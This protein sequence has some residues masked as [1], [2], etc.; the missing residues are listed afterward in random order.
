MNK[1]V[2][3]D[4]LSNIKDLLQT[5]KLPQWIMT[6]PEIHQ[7]EIEKIFSKK[8]YFIAHESEIPNKGDYVSRWIV[9]DPVLLIRNGEGDINAFI[10]SCTHRGVHLC[11]ADLG[12]KKTFTC[13]YHGWTYNIEGELVGILAGNK[14]YGE[15]MDKKEWGLRKVPKVESYHGLIFASLNPDVESLEEF[16]G[17]MK[18][19]FDIML[20]R[21][22]KGMEVIGAP[23]RWVVDTNWKV[24]A[25]VFVGDAY[26]TAMTHRSTVELGISPKDPLFASNGY[27]IQLEN[28]HGLNVIQPPASVS[29]PPYQGLPE[30]LWP[31]FQENLTKEQLEVFKNTMVFNG[32]CFPNLS[33]LSP[34]HGKGEHENLTNFLTIRQW[35]PLGPDKIE[36]WSWVLVDK[37]APEEF[38]E[39]SY[40]RYVNTFGPGGTLEQDDTELW[41]RL[42]DAS[43]GVTARDKNLHFNNVVNYLMGMDFVEPVEDFPGPGIAYPTTFLDV[44]HRGFYE[45]WQELISKES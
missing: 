18:W 24:S 13:P 32:N 45:Y 28:G 35:R 7:L 11:T 15:E 33:F 22:N 20:G 2:N 43:K 14:L 17:G 27:Q 10:N 44:V 38:K 39:N 21:S 25:E 12:N 34:M 37:E 19:Y 30:E 8:W 29:I 5:G 42:A 3:K 6:D 31:M 16:L 4:H 41:T 23:Q 36:A 9:H 26:H 1:T 40:K